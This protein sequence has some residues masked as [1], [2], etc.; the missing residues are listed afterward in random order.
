MIKPIKLKRGD[1]VATI[2][3]SN[4][5]AGEKIFRHRYELGKK[6]LEQDFGLRVAETKNSLNGIKYLSEHPEKRAK[7]LMSA[8]ENPEIKAI[9][10]NIGGDDTIR[11]LPYI[12]FNII[13]NNPKIFIGYSD[14]TVNHF[15]MY[16]AGVVSYYGPAVMSE[17]AENCK[18]HDYTKKYIKEVLFDNKDRITIESSLEWTSELLDW[19]DQSNNN[20]YRKMNKEK[21]GYELIQGKTIFE[22][23]L[24]GGCIDV[25]PMIIGTEI[26]PKKEEWKNK[27]LYLETSENEVRPTFI[28]YIL[29][30]LIVQG[31][32]D[33]INGIIVGKPKNEKYYEEYKEVYHRLI[34]KEAKRPDLPILFNVN[35]G[36][37]SPM[38]ILPNG[39]KVR[40][41]F[42]N[43][44]IIF[45]ERPMSDSIS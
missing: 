27:I 13:H 32:I 23:M 22:G 37:T 28:E 1:C 12:D 33:K 14:T 34:G 5:M 9:I 20:I 44:E 17:F 7:D 29:R 16:K 3:L 36:H 26:W 31:I 41:D 6:R 15:M 25:F 42:N 24:L 39:I 2:S 4:G 43:K 19:C 35:F 38:C 40:V 11:L 10:S 45:L 8:F 30:N 18:M 21:H